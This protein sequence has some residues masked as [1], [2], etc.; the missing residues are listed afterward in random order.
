MDKKI[1]RNK[2]DR[3]KKILSDEDQITE[4]LQIAVREAVEMHKRGGNPVAAW[5]NGKAVLIE[6]NKL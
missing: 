4:I 2:K 6:A 3:I 1:K 5:K